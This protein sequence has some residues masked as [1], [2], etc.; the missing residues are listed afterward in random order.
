MYS[1]IINSRY[2]VVIITIV[3]IVLPKVLPSNL[4]TNYVQ[5]FVHSI[6]LFLS[7]WQFWIL[8]KKDSFNQTLPILTLTLTFVLAM[9]SVLKVIEL[10]FRLSILI[11]GLLQFLHKTLISNEK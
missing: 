5:M 10:D 9:L 4:N 3:A 7:I 1:K 8:F 2:Y 6:F 11:Y